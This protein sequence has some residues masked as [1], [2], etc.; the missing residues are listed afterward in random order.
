MQ[1]KT[2]EA[3]RQAGTEISDLIQQAQNLVKKAEAIADE[4]NIHF[5]MNLTETYGMGG[6]YYPKARVKLDTKTGK[7][8]DDSSGSENEGWQSSSHSC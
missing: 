8:D 3:L 5:S 1:V 4:H 7:F 6:Y 2:S